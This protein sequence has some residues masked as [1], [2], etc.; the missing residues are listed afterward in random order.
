M[1]QLG[2]HYWDEGGDI[3]KW[4]NLF[5]SVSVFGYIAANVYFGMP[6][7]K[8]SW[9]TGPLRVPKRHRSNPAF[10]TLSHNKDK[11]REHV[12]F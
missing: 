6:E 8:M 1:N 5:Y 9:R 12:T 7:S 4:N 10:E 2:C 3:N 11:M